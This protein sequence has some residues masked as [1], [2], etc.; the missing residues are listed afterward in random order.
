MDKKNRVYLSDQMVLIGLGIGLAYW[1][2]ECFLYVFLSYQIN[3][4]DRLLGPSFNDL[5]TR[6]VVI[7]LFLFF[8]S[9]AQYTINKRKRIE[10]ELSQLKEMN[11]KLKQDIEVQKKKGASES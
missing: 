3:F 4:I 8:G 7:C 11:E 1:I 6:I 5:S 10:E 9:H 2:I